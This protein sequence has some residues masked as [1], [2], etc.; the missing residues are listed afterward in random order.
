MVSITYGRFA[1]T[2]AMA[3]KNNRRCKRKPCFMVFSGDGLPLLSRL[4]SSPC[5]FHLFL[6]VEKALEA[7]SK[8]RSE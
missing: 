4:E 8:I 6:A 3:S 7:D 5:K 2:C 1:D